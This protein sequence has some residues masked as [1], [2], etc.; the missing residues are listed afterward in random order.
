MDD[1]IGKLAIEMFSH[2]LKII[3]ALKKGYSKM[4]TKFEEGME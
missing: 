4:F 3:S 1:A 2:M